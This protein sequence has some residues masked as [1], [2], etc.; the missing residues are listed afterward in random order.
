MMPASAA[1]VA[2]RSEVSS[3][4]CTTT[5]V[6]AG[7][8]FARAIRRSYFDCGGPATGPTAASVPISL[9]LVS[10][11]NSPDRLRGLPQGRLEGLLFIDA[12]QL[13]N[14]LEPFFRL[15]PDLAAG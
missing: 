4:G 5:V 15:T 12:E 3:H 1:S 6:A 13:A 8:S 11:T 9:S 10:T 14:A 2:P 7:T